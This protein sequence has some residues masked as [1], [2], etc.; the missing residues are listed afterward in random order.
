MLRLNRAAVGPLALLVSVLVFQMVA[1]APAGAQT[2]F[3]LLG[4]AYIPA[5]DF[6]EIRDGARTVGAAREAALGLGLNIEMGMFRASLAYATGAT[7]TDGGVQDGADLGD[8]TV[9]AGAL[10]GV[11]RPI[12]RILVQPYLV[13]GVGAKRQGFSFEDATSASSTDLALHF[14]IGA[15]LMLGGLGAVLEVTDFV[16]RRPDSGGGQHDAFVMVG[17]RLRL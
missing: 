2:R 1:A 11:L 15:D 13:G 8:G 7:L 10:G 17:V 4:G 12:P 3:T 6:Y 9:L 14:G 5:T 16:S